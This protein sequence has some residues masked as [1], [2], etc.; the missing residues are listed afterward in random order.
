MR[1]LLVLACF[2]P[3]AAAA[4]GTGPA[5]RADRLLFWNLT[6]T[7]VTSLTMAPAGTEAFGSNQCLNDRDK[8]VDHD[9]R[10][11][12]TEITPGMYDVR[13][14]NKR[15][16]ACVIRNVEVKGGARI[17]FSLTDDDLKDC[18]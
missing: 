6:S 4:Q 9:E 8:E 12:L 7:T 18:K 1:A 13:I 15:V 14:T 17:A 5:P 2:A 16:R 11:R 10:L 3:L